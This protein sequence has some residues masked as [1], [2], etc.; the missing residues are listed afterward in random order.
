MCANVSP[1]PLQGKGRKRGF[2]IIRT[3]DR[4]GSSFLFNNVLVRYV[5]TCPE[6]GI[7]FYCNNG[8]GGV[9]GVR[10]YPDGRKVLGNATTD[11]TPNSKR[12]YDSKRK[13]RYLVFKHAFGNEKNIL[14]SHAVWMAAGRTIPVGMTLDHIDGCTT[15]NYIG[16]LRCV[17]GE[18]NCRDGGFLTKLRRKGFNTSRIDRAYLLRF[19]ERMA[20]IKASITEY[21]YR[22]LNKEQLRSILFLPDEELKIDSLIQTLKTP[23]KL[24]QTI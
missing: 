7:S 6:T 4:E 11:T 21:R 19:Y 15:N 14:A 13:Q 2:E 18:I 1:C 9:L 23:K 8:E 24:C 17:S 20:K 12:G 3:P 5:G 16:N 10:V 22:K